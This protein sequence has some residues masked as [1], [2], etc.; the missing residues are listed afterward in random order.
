MHDPRGATIDDQQDRHAR[1]VR[2][3]IGHYMSDEIPQ[4][5]GKVDFGTKNNK[6][7][8]ASI[9]WRLPGLEP[10]CSHTRF[11]E[12]ERAPPQRRA[13]FI[14]K[15]SKQYRRLGAPASSA[16]SLRFG[17]MSSGVLKSSAGLVRCKLN[18]LFEW[19]MSIHTNAHVHSTH[20]SGCTVRRD[21]PHLFSTSSA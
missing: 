3:T 8:N 12:F 4:R 14:A 16:A 17:H 15:A 18:R 20:R 7:S 5:D 19:C 11:R 6:T 2:L 9:S 13:W 1:R 21:S 10:G